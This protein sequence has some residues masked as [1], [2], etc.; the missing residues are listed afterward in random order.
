MKEL[1]DDY[2]ISGRNVKHYSFVLGDYILVADSVL[3]INIE[4]TNTYFKNR[5]M[6]VQS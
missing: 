2:Y 5:M 3:D 6:F 4:N 1:A